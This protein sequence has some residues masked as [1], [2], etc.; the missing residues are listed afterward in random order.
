MKY[1]NHFFYNPL[2][3]NY[4]LE[5]DK[6]QKQDKNNKTQNWGLAFENKNFVQRQDIK[7]LLRGNK[8]IWLEGKNKILVR[9][10]QN[11]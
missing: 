9:L 4:N 1:K 2:L 8:H 7:T 5:R 6:W 3:I 11:N 10:S